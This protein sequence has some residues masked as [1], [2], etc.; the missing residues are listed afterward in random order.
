MENKFSKIG[1]PSVVPT[2]LV[3]MVILQHLYGLRSLRQTV[4]EIKDGLKDAPHTVI[5]SGTNICDVLVACGACKSKREARD[6][7]KGNSISLNGEKINDH[8]LTLE[9]DDAFDR[10]LSIIKKG[11]KNWYVIGFEG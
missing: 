10:E 5:T 7:I 6:L 2:V 4:A 8:E 11:R 1:R 9:V 3:K